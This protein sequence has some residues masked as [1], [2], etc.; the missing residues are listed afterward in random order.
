MA[1]PIGPTIDTNE[2]WGEG[3]CDRCGAEDV[4]LFCICADEKVCAKCLDRD[5]FQCEECNQHWDLS[6]L[7][8]REGRQ[9]CPDCVS[10][11]DY[12]HEPGTNGVARVK[13][14]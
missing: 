12:E 2:V 11:Y 1:L 6:V 13:A 10:A 5:F 14:R 3:T 9:L 4:E 8:S 7:D